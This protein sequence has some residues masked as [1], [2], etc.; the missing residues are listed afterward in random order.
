MSSRIDVAIPAHLRNAIEPVSRAIDA[1]SA[2]FDTT[3]PLRLRTA[4]EPISQAIDAQASTSRQM[5]RNIAASQSS[6][7]NAQQ[8]LRN[9]LKENMTIFKTEMQLL[10]SSVRNNSVVLTQV[11]DNVVSNAR[12][13]PMSQQLASPSERMGRS[14]RTLTFATRELLLAFLELVWPLILLLLQRMQAAT[15]RLTRLLISDS[16]IFEDALGR[17]RYLPFEFFQHWDVFLPYL[18]KTFE[19]VP[20]LY[21][22]SRRRYHLVNT[23][24]GTIIDP[25]LWTASVKPGSCLSMA[26]VAYK[27]AHAKRACPHCGGSQKWTGPDTFATW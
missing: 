25:Q 13:T 17:T 22:I 8:A 14:L 20:G 19:Q 6:L 2:S 23:R 21:G 27:I 7:S 10:Q 11:R 24:T 12:S 9:S 16:I 1:L 18:H 3:I 26:M 15:T 5:V 4:M